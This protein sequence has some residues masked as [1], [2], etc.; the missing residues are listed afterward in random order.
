[1][2]EDLIKREDVIQALND[3]VDIKGYAYSSLHDAIMEIP[4]AEA[5]PER[6]N[7]GV[8][9]EYDNGMVAM[10]HETFDEYHAIAVNDAIR[11][12]FWEKL[13]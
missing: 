12:G 4:K 10:T 11:K 9:K 3:C 7:I 6:I 5:I 13:P 2:I 8:I 1:M